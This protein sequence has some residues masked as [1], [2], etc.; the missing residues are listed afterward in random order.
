MPPSQKDRGR[1][2]AQ[3]RGRATIAPS[4]K[5]NEG[6]T[7]CGARTL[8]RTSGPRAFPPAGTSWL[9]MW[10]AFDQII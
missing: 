7:T 4:L 9:A 10:V 5:C 1:S 8:P 2:R 6:R 3:R